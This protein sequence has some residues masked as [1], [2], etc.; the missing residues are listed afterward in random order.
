MKSQNQI[1]KC[2]RPGG[3]AN[4]FSWLAVATCLQ[5][6]LLHSMA[7]VEGCTLL[8]LKKNHARGSQPGVI[9]TYIENLNYASNATSI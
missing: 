5:A 2:I 4:I 8:D 1:K 6:S 7:V 9:T 3:Q